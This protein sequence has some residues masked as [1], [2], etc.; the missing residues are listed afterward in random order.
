MDEEKN[1]M[2][3][4]TRAKV[5]AAIPN[6]NTKSVIGEVVSRAKKYKE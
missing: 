6:L 1:T 2:T 3:R 5:V 4:P